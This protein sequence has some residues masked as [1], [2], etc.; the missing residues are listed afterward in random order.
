MSLVDPY[1]G[2]VLVLQNTQPWV[3]LASFVGFLLAALMGF[4]GFDGAVGGLAAHRFETAPF[5]LLDFVFAVAFLV[6]ALYL[7]KYASRIG[8]F[9]AQGHHVQLEAA[10][11]AQRKFW[12][13][14]GLFA[15]AS[16]ILLTLAAGLALI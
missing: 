8:V 11:E 3:R 5:I 7:H 12:K 15:L 14:S 13:F 16:L 9:V 6:P 2:T 1:A 4:L 10:L